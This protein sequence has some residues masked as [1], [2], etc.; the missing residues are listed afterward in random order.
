MCFTTYNHILT[1]IMLSTRTTRTA[2]VFS[3][4][5]AFVVSVSQSF[6]FAPKREFYQLKVYHLKD[7]AQQERLES[8]LQQAYVPALHRAGIEKVGVFKTASEAAPA[9]ATSPGST[10]APAEQLLYVLIPLKSVEQFMG[11]SET[12]AKDK[13]YTSAGKDYLDAAF[14]NPI[15]NR[16]ES[17]LMESFTGMPALMAPKLQSGPSERIYELRNYEA[18]TEKLHENKIS[19][20][21]NGELDIFKRL[22]FNTV[23][24]GQVKAGGKLPSMMYMTSFEN[25][26][27]RDAHWKA[28]SADPAWKTLNALP[29][30]AHNFLRADIYLL[31]PTTYSE[32]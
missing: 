23:F 1:F 18:A 27:E 15:Y 19:Q 21:N 5:L 12:L 20:F 14:D 31:H 4:L 8:Y 11:L 17:V 24:C 6:G 25:K 32:I 13:Q 3:F 26:T 28:F 2:F 22:G 10:T 29:E 9:S 7:N 16:F 30:Y